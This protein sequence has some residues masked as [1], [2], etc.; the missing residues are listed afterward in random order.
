MALPQPTALGDMRDAGSALLWSHT[1]RVAAGWRSKEVAPHEPGGGWQG[2]KV[3]GQGG[4]SGGTNGLYTG[5]WI[6]PTL[7]AGKEATV[8][9][10]AMYRDGAVT[11]R[12]YLCDDGWYQCR[13]VVGGRVVLDWAQGPNPQ[14]AKCAMIAAVSRF[15]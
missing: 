11:G 12:V 10:V 8:T 1:S 14:S 3:P 9:E 6:G 5:R 15:A 7:V 13:V 2:P 4:T